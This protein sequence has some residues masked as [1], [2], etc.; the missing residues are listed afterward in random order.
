MVSSLVSAVES[1]LY[2]KLQFLQDLFVALDKKYI[3]L[4]DT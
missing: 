2:G 4:Y 1:C 3:L